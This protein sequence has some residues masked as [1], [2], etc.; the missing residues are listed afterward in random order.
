MMFKKILMIGFDKNDLEQEYWDRINKI[1]EELVMLAKDSP[2]I[3][4]HLSNT[5]CLLVK[6]GA[7]VNK[8]TM[9]NAPN[10]KYIGVFGTGYGKIDTEYATDKG[11]AVCNIA[12]YSTEAVAEFAFAIILEQLRDLE[13]GKKQARNTN[14]S[15]S[16]FF[17]VYE[18]KAKKFGI[19]GLGRI[20]SRIAEIALGFGADVRYW[21][22]T[23]K[24]E[25]ETKGIRYQEIETVL[26]EC[27]FLS[28]NLALNKEME[29]FLN[30]SRIEKIK[31]GAVVINLA[32]MELVDIDALAKRLEKGD[33]TFMLDHSDEMTPEQLKQLTKCKNCIVYPPI[34]Y[35]TK[36]ATSEKQEAFA[37]NLENFLKG[38]PTNKVN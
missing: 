11:I 23:R 8:K 32:P 25:Y 6:I 28:L 29:G 17:N 2:D 4:K 16:T 18:I 34:A 13:R 12:G 14:Y 30:G 19:I 9:D 31:S 7:T 3:L 36:E 35:T 37:N 10:L 24:K 26:A 38:T 33:I 27:D 21:S 15:E 22:R 1:T 20:G 5:D